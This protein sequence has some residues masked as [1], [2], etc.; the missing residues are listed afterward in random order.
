MLCQNCGK[1][2]VNFRYTQIIN[3]VKKE[4]A[5]CDKC[6]RELGFE[7]IDFSMPIDFSSFLGDFLNDYAENTF[8]PTFTKTQVLKCNH[9]GTTFDE[10]A[11]TGELG[12][13]YCYNTF[14][15]RIAPVLRNLHGSSKHLG[16]TY[17]HWLDSEEEKE[18]KSELKMKKEAKPQK[19]E[20]EIEKLQKELQQVIKEENYEQAAKIRDQIKELEKKNKKEEK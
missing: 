13:G 1:N 16:R 20:S 3:G 7:G 9:C 17:K 6:A 15:D 11:S 5:L 4:W 19:K 10:F 14:A 12:C 8:L 2:E 18:E